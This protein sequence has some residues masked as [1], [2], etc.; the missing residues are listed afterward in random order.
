VTDIFSQK[1]TS[2]NKRKD[3]EKIK[4]LSE[5]RMTVFHYCETYLNEALTSLKEKLNGNVDISIY[6]CGLND[7]S[8]SHYYFGQIIK[9]A[10]KHDYY[11]NRS[12][13]KAWILFRIDLSIEKSY[14]L[15]I[16]IHHYG[17]E[18]NTLAI[19]AFLEFL[20]SDS[21]KE[22]IDTALPLDIKPHVISIDEHVELKE[23]NIRSYLEDVLTLTLAQIASEI[24]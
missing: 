15:G 17:Y 20:S 21:E 4:T 3:D 9:Y 22:R 2:W 24:C 10:K 11:F 19:G 12:L 6:S 23:K 16:T 18:E 7:N 14:Q 5:N 13:P 8:K 1:I